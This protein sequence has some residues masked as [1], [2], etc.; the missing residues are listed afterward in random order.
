MHDSIFLSFRGRT[1]QI[2]RS[3]IQELLAVQKNADDLMEYVVQV[4]V[5]VRIFEEF[6]GSLMSNTDHEVTGENA[7]ALHLLA[8]EFRLPQLMARCAAVPA[9]ELVLDT[10]SHV[11]T[12]MNMRAQ[13]VVP[14][15]ESRAHRSELERL[16]LA[17]GGP[18]SWGLLRAMGV[19]PKWQCSMGSAN[20]SLRS[21]A[22]V[23]GVVAYLGR[24]NPGNLHEMAL[25]TVISSSLCD[26]DPLSALENILYFEP[27]L[28]FRSEDAPYQ[29]ICWT[30]HFRYV[31]VK[32]YAIIASG[33]Q[34]W[35]LEGSVDAQTWFMIDRQMST[36][37][38]KDGSAA[39]TFAVARPA[40]C[41]YIRLVQTG[42]NHGDQDINRLCLGGVEFFGTLFEPDYQ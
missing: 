14:E 41:R 36:H 21:P 30:F 22:C 39:A 33:L 23:C 28:S 27:S 20:C 4:W 16:W 5:R 31:L 10:H 32:H 13:L 1:Y 17:P 9:P 18:A 11:P 34:S 42:P 25:V 8:S 19:T 40:K 37:E 38:F 35:M 26:G 3:C 24:M 6:V 12:P 15:R 7:A 2:P 29:W